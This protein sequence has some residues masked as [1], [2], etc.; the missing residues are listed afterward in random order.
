M[1]AVGELAPDFEMLTDEGKKV[2]LS[3][4]RGKKV[5]LYFYPKDFTS[6]CELQACNFRD[7][8]AKLAAHNTV[9][10][11]VSPDDVESHK[12]FREAL[13]LPFNLLVDA[14]HTYAK[15]WG[16]Y[17]MRKAGDPATLGIIRSQYVIDE[18]GKIIATH[19]PVPAPESF[20]KALESVEK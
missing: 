2:K 1:P 7:G 16:A 20:K 10:L 8:Y 19:A 5:V 14:D 3:S 11:G 12:K 4:F 15:A 18:N 17:G 13:K 9:V 6:G